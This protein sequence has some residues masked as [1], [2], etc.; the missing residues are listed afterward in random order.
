MGRAHEE[1]DRAAG[2]RLNVPLLVLWSLRDDLEQ[3][4]GDPLLIW[5]DWA[6][7][8]RGHGIDSGHHIAEEARAALADALTDFLPQQRD[9]RIR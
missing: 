8:L 9:N 2:H 4:Y 1:V 6:T 3:L 5:E 7:N